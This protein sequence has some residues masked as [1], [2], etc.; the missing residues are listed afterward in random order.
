MKH[1]EFWMRAASLIVAV[2]ALGIYQA[3]ALQWQREEEANQLAVQRAQTHNAEAMQAASDT[4]G[5]S[6]QDGV[7]TGSG[8]GFGGTVSVEVT[9]SGGKMT[10]ITVTAASGE[11]TAYLNRA[12]QMIDSMLAAQSADVDTISGATFSSNGIKTAVQ[13]A[14]EGAKK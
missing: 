6:Y 12:M 10:G 8:E 3:N 13:Q 9:V 4:A 7:Y 11:D 5:A 1:Q 2:G 14:L